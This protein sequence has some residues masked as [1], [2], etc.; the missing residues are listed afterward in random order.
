MP[1]H[2]TVAPPP[3]SPL[4][5]LVVTGASLLATQA[6]PSPTPERVAFE[7]WL[8]GQARSSLDARQARVAAL[9]TRD[10]VL[11]RQR[12]VRVQMAESLGLLP[13]V[14][15]PLQAV[16]TRTTPREGYR[17]EHVRFESAPGFHV[18]ANAYVPD[19]PGPFPAVV[20][21]AGH[22][23]EGKAS[24]V[25]QHAWVSLARRGF[26]VL[27]IDPFGQGERVEYPDAAGTGSRVGIGTREHSMTGQQVLLTGRTIG[28]YMVR[29]MQ[30]ALDYLIARPDV[31]ATR[32]AVAGNSGGGTQAALLGAVD[33][34]LAAVVVS[35]YMTSWKEMWAVPG[36]QDAEQIL[37]GFVSRGLDFADFAIAVAPRGFLVSSAIKDFFPIA[38][39]R[40]ASA[41]LTRLYGLLGAGDRA[42]SRG[43]RRHAR[44]DT[45]PARRRVRRARS[46]ARSPRVVPG[47]GAGHAR[48]HRS[49]ARDGYGSARDV[50]RL[51]HG[52]RHQRR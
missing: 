43:E 26:L 42:R 9:S 6:V 16:V 41:E 10:A 14:R 35:C 13:E 1:R 23:D 44:V 2:G 45:A 4:L 39:S 20:G 33:A 47:R 46:L 8:E 17:I 51:A 5:A 21:T 19:G 29:D 31:D 34:R 37:P 12:D 36:P 52:A 27:A 22:A 24:P 11:A 28:A 3:R 15:T 30:R 18:T 40:A 48:T 38:G 49:P 32:L 50:G 25:Y 7:T